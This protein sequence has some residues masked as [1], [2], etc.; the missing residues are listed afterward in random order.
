ML[1]DVLRTQQS[2]LPG[3]EVLAVLLS[4]DARLLLLLQVVLQLARD[5]GLLL[6]NVDHARPHRRRGLGTL[7]QPVLQLHACFLLELLAVLLRLAHGLRGAVL[8]D[9]LRE[10]H[11]QLEHTRAAARCQRDQDSTKGNGFNPQCRSCTTP[12]RCSRPE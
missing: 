9:L 11:G 4:G 7:Q 2:D 8:L 12:T 1:L 3:D 10:V 6:E 5:G